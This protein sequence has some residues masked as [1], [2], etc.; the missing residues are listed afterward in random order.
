MAEQTNKLKAIVDGI[1][2]T[3]CDRVYHQLA[4][5]DALYPHVVYDIRRVEVGDLYRRDYIIEAHAWANDE[6]RMQAADIADRI[7]AAFDQLNTPEDGCFPTFYL[8]TRA[9]AIEEDKALTHEVVQI[10]AQ[11][12]WED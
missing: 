8:Y 1:L 7:E 3:T 9:N 6:D 12:Y 2:R 11:T 4:D 10:T 5:E